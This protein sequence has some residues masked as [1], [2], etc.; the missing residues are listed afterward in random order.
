M[1]LAVGEIPPLRGAASIEDS[2]AAASMHHGM[3]MAAGQDVA[4]TEPHYTNITEGV[5]P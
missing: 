5:R 3:T 1:R 4:L 2:S